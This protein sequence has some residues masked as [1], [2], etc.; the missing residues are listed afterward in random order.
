M[1]YCD[2]CL[3]AQIF[4]NG[5]DNLTIQKVQMIQ[6]RFKCFLMFMIHMINSIFNYFSIFNYCVCPSVRLS[7]RDAFSGKLDH[8]ILLIFCM[9]LDN[10]NISLVTSADFLK[11]IRG[12][13][14]FR[15]SP[16][17]TKKMCQFPFLRKSC[18]QFSFE[19]GYDEGRNILL[20]FC[21]N[22]MSDKNLVLEIL[23]KL[24]TL[25]CS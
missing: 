2:I 9:K 8:R 17:I 12:R 21:E 16:K 1:A 15:F 11:K 18:H 5:M 7:V 10:H 25:C 3:Q 14:E 13:H 20:S 23:V 22:R 24:E 4:S 19:R 6:V